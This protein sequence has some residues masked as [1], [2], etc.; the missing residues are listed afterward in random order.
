MDKAT[1]IQDIANR[2]QQILN[3]ALEMKNESSIDP[4]TSYEGRLVSEWDLLI[5]TI[6]NE[7]KQIIEMTSQ[8][9]ERVISKEDYDVMLSQRQAEQKKVKLPKLKMA[10]GNDE[11]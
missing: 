1:M 11:E 2:L 6:I 7:S 8:L 9:P 4:I 5:G 3:I 10:G